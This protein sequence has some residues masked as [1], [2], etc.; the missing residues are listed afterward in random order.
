MTTAP[1]CS[2][3]GAASVIYFDFSCA[4]LLRA[5][6]EKSCNAGFNDRD[7][8]TSRVALSACSLSW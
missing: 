4:E 7:R 8:E 5:H 3:D 6:V 2:K 1:P